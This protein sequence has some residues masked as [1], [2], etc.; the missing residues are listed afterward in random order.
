MWSFSK[1]ERTDL[2]IPDAIMT[3]ARSGLEARFSD[4]FY[5]FAGVTDESLKRA[6]EARKV[7]DGLRTSV[8]IIETQQENIDELF[9]Y[10]E[11]MVKAIDNLQQQSGK[12]QVRNI[13]LPG[14]SIKESP[15]KKLGYVKL[16]LRFMNA[17]VLHFMEETMSMED[18]IKSK[19]MI[20]KAIA[21]EARA[22]P[23]I[24]R[25]QDVELDD[26]SSN[27]PIV[28][29]RTAPAV[30]E[31]DIDS[32]LDEQTPS[33]ANKSS[34][35]TT[36]ERAKTPQSQRMSKQPLS[37]TTAKGNAKSKK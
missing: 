15:G 22:I 10:A 30:D 32:I 21:D 29:S 31:S 28:S 6:D 35:T 9:T 36:P 20:I 13:P 7:A 37:P 8:G 12:K 5:K 1:H 17:G 23:L 4:R 2:E 24:G 33:E 3:A 11:M 14:N 27:D 26:L 34:V 18:E 19:D 25:L 16:V